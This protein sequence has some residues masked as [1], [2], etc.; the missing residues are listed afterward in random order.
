MA[1]TN[2]TDT[3]SVEDNRDLQDKDEKFI[4]GSIVSTYA[5]PYQLDKTNIIITA[6]NHFTPPL[7]VV[8]EKKY[9]STNYNP[10]TG[11][12]EYNEQCKCIY[13]CTQT[14]VLEEN[15]FKINQLRLI[16]EGNLSFYKD[17]KDKSILEL[18][19]LIGQKAILTSVDLELGKK[20]AWFD[21]N[22]TNKKLK[23]KTLLDFL[24]PLGTIIA[25]EIVQDSRKFDEKKGNTLYRK[26][27]LRVK[28]RWWNNHTSKFSEEYFPMTA[29]KLINEKDLEIISY[30]NS[31]LQKPTTITLEDSTI[32][33][34]STPCSLEEIIWKHY[35]YVYKY[36]NLFTNEI[37]LLKREKAQSIKE[38]EN[39]DPKILESIFSNVEQ[40]NSPALNFFSDNSDDKKNRW[41]KIEYLDKLNRLTQRIIFINEI[42]EEEHLSPFL[43]TQKKLTII[44][45]CLLRNGKI[46][47]FNVSRILKFKEIPAEFV[48]AFITPEPHALS[49]ESAAA[50]KE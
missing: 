37:I 18:N 36:R 16:H 48:K 17:N 9:S 39:I 44:G 31:Y 30:T 2:N 1:N 33:I 12:K 13:Y 34:K 20:Q 24:P 25:F 41:F 42:K 29:L 4:L 47:H 40:N 23:S 21:E 15:W 32:S 8:V 7:M 3:L 6:Y 45:N 22:T 43:E 5:H 28:I 50:K 14:G 38:I 19:K 49:V 46:R 10:E 11:D 26:S 27:K 35:Y